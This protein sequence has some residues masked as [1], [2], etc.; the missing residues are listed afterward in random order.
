MFSKKNWYSGKPRGEL[1]ELSTPNSFSASATAMS[2]VAPFSNSNR[3]STGYVQR[4]KFNREND[5][6]RENHCEIEEGTMGSMKRFG[7]PSFTEDIS[8]HTGETCMSPLT[9]ERSFKDRLERLPSTCSNP[10]PFD[11]YDDARRNNGVTD[12]SSCF[13]SG[14]MFN[15][16]NA[17]VTDNDDDGSKTIQSEVSSI[18]ELSVDGLNTFLKS[19]HQVTEVNL[20]LSLQSNSNYDGESLDSKSSSKCL[21]SPQKSSVYGS[22]EESVKTEASFCGMMISNKDS[23]E[24]EAYY[25][26]TERKLILDVQD[27]ESTDDKDIIEWMDSEEENISGANTTGGNNAK[28][29]LKDLNEE[30]EPTD[31]TDDVTST[32]EGRA[33]LTKKI[34]AEVDDLIEKD[35]YLISHE[36]DQVKESSTEE[37]KHARIPSGTIEDLLNCQQDEPAHHRSLFMEA[38][39]EASGRVVQSV[40]TLSENDKYLTNNNDSQSTN[41]FLRE[42]RKSLEEGS[43]CHDVT[44]HHNSE[45]DDNSPVMSLPENDSEDSSSNLMKVL[46]HATQKEVG[47][48]NFTDMKHDT[49]GS[50]TVYSEEVS[51]DSYKDS[52]SDESFICPETEEELDLFLN[53]VSPFLTV[54][55]RAAGQDHVQFT[56]LTITRQHSEDLLSLKYL[57]SDEISTA[58]VKENEETSTSESYRPIDGNSCGYVPEEKDE[59]LLVHETEPM[60]GAELKDVLTSSIHSSN[61]YEHDEPLHSIKLNSEI[62][63]AALHQDD[64]KLPAQ[65][66]PSGPEPIALWTDV[67]YSSCLE[68]QK[69]RE[70]AY[71]SHE[72]A[73]KNQLDSEINTAVS[74]NVADPI[75]RHSQ[76]DLGQCCD[77]HTSIQRKENI[78]FCCNPRDAYALEESRVQNTAHDPELKEAWFDSSYSSQEE[79]LSTCK[80]ND[81]SN[82]N[83]TKKHLQLIDNITLLKEEVE[84]PG[85]EKTLGNQALDEPSQCCDLLTEASFG[86]ERPL[87]RHIL[88]QSQLNTS[89][90]GRNTTSVV[91]DPEEEKINSDQTMAIGS[92]PPSGISA[93][94]LEDEPLTNEECDFASEKPSDIVIEISMCN[95]GEELRKG[96][97]DLAAFGSPS[98]PDDAER[99]SVTILK[100]VHHADSV[101]YE[102]LIQ[103]E[104]QNTESIELS[105][106]YENLHLYKPINEDEK[107]KYDMSIESDC[108]KDVAAPI[109]NLSN[110]D[111]F[112]GVTEAEWSCKPLNDKRDICIELDPSKHV[113]APIHN[114]SDRD[115]VKSVTETASYDH[116]E[117]SRKEAAIDLTEATSDI[118]F[119]LLSKA[120]LIVESKERPCLS[121]INNL[122]DILEETGLQLH[123]TTVFQIMLVLSLSQPSAWPISLSSRFFSLINNVAN[124]NFKSLID[125]RDVIEEVALLQF[126]FVLNQFAKARASLEASLTYGDRFAILFDSHFEM[127]LGLQLLR[128]QSREIEDHFDIPSIPLLQSLYSSI[129]Q[130]IC[131][132]K[133]LDEFIPPEHNINSEERFLINT[134]AFP[135][136]MLHECR[137]EFSCSEGALVT[138]TIETTLLHDSVEILIDIKN[139][140][141]I[142]STTVVTASSVCFSSASASCEAN[143]SRVVDKEKTHD[144]FKNIPTRPASQSNLFLMDWDSFSQEVEGIAGEMKGPNPI[145]PCTA[146]IDPCVDIVERKSGRSIKDLNDQEQS[147]LLI[148]KESSSLD[149]RDT[150]LEMYYTEL[151]LV[152]ETNR[153]N[154]SLPPTKEIDGNENRSD[155]VESAAEQSVPGAFQIQPTKLNQEVSQSCIVDIYDSMAAVAINEHFNRV[156]CDFSEDSSASEK[157]V[158]SLSN[159]PANKGEGIQESIPVTLQVGIIADSAN[160]NTVSPVKCDSLGD[161]AKGFEEINAEIHDKME[162]NGISVDNKEHSNSLLIEVG[163]IEKLIP[164]REKADF[165]EDLSFLGQMDSLISNCVE[166]EVEEIQ[167]FIS[168]A[169]DIG[170]KEFSPNLDL[171]NEH[172]NSISDIDDFM[173]A[174]N[175]SVIKNKNLK[176]APCN[177]FDD[178]FASGQ[179]DYSVSNGNDLVLEENESSLP[180]TKNIGIHADFAIHSS[181]SG[182]TESS[183]SHPIEIGVGDSQYSTSREHLD[184]PREID[185]VVLNECEPSLCLNNKMSTPK[186]LCVKQD[187]IFS[188]LN[189]LK[190]LEFPLSPNFP[191][192]CGLFMPQKSESID[193]RD[194]IEMYE[195][196]FGP[197]EE[198]DESKQAED[199]FRRKSDFGQLAM[200]EAKGDK[201]RI[202]Q[203]KLA[204][205][206]PNIIGYSSEADIIQIPVETKSQKTAQSCMAEINGTRNFNDESITTNNLFYPAQGNLAEV[207]SS[208]SRMT[209]CSG[210]QVGELENSTFATTT[211]SPVSPMKNDNVEFVDESEES[212]E[213]EKGFVASPEHYSSGIDVVENAEETKQN[214][215]ALT[216][217]SHTS[218]VVSEDSKCDESL[219]LPA[220]NSQIYLIGEDNFP[221]E[222]DNHLLVNSQQGSLNH[223]RMTTSMVKNIIHNSKVCLDDD[224]EAKKIKKCCIETSVRRSANSGPP[225]GSEELA[226]VESAGA[227][228]LDS[229]TEKVKQKEFVSEVSSLP[230]SVKSTLGEGEDSCPCPE[231]IKEVDAGLNLAELLEVNTGVAYSSSS[232]VENEVKANVVNQSFSLA[233]SISGFDHLKTLECALSTCFSEETCLIDLKQSLSTVS[234]DMIQQFETKFGPMEEVD[235]TEQAEDYLR[236]CLESNR[237]ASVP[238][239]HHSCCA[240]SAE[241]TMSK[242]SGHDQEMTETMVVFIDN[243]VDC[244]K[245]EQM[246]LACDE[247]RNPQATFRAFERPDGSSSSGSVIH[248]SLSNLAEKDEL[249]IADKIHNTS[250]PQTFYEL[251]QQKAL[252]EA[253]STC[254]SQDRSK[255]EFAES[256]DIDGF[257]GLKSNKECANKKAVLSICTQRV[258]AENASFQ[259]T[260]IPNVNTSAM[261]RIDEDTFTS[262]GSSDMISKYEAKFGPMAEVDE[263]DQAI[264]F[265]NRFL[266]LKAGGHFPN[267]HRD[268]VIL[269]E[270]VISVDE[271]SQS[272]VEVDLVLGYVKKEFFVTFDD[273]DPVNDAIIEV[274]TSKSIDIQKAVSD[275]RDDMN[276]EVRIEVND[277]RDYEHLVELQNN[278]SETRQEVDETPQLNHTTNPEMLLANKA[279][280]LGQVSMKAKVGM[281][282]PVFVNSRTEMAPVINRY[283]S[284]T[285]D[286]SVVSSLSLFDFEC[287]ARSQ[288]PEPPCEID[289]QETAKA[290]IIHVKKDLVQSAL[291][292]F[293][294][295][296]E[297]EEKLLKLE[298]QQAQVALQK[299]GVVMLGWKSPWSHHP[300]SHLLAFSDGHINGTAAAAFLS[301]RRAIIFPRQQKS[302]NYIARSC[303][304]GIDLISFNESMDSTCHATKLDNLPWEHRNVRQRFLSEKS[305]ETCNWFG[306]LLMIRGND[307]NHLPV[308]HPSSAELDWEIIP[309]PGSW[310]ENWFTPWQA[311]RANPNNLLIDQK[312]SND[313]EDSED[314]VGERP[315]IGVL[316]TVRQNINESLT[317]VSYMHSSNL[318]RSRWRRKFYPYGT[319]PF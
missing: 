42:S 186:N 300:G 127:P 210:I 130:N 317:R 147:S 107:L 1:S 197:M 155:Q 225:E 269:P 66:T 183:M 46:I 124:Q 299:H 43:Q 163:N 50:T 135:C 243:A 205:T 82:E 165:A 133:A 70:N 110:R 171:S 161:F 261:V 90:Q 230:S 106:K 176:P 76:D 6:D 95:Q 111:S 29:M 315:Q 126:Y 102:Q 103:F 11:R 249:Q 85:M 303:K 203:I 100:V 129:K 178:S 139:D 25:I 318:R 319:F 2:D 132:H 301:R 208:P 26:S 316:V 262:E 189:Q 293:S 13:Q 221:G 61:L 89:L 314:L 180:I 279:V 258:M 168:V 240:G 235:V 275:E 267:A 191:E 113:A 119:K 62:T 93:T 9:A 157:T 51:L 145:I 308:S 289:L 141:L 72:S 281:T 280:P 128:A 83:V 212:G 22:D 154:L 268:S 36:D 310:E 306:S 8:I 313:S 285:D 238:S 122:F 192:A 146:N 174:N 99:H 226:I 142:Q 257:K 138:E 215:C 81:S 78:E 214:S 54:T 172:E 202:Q 144:T 167:D 209:G 63:S 160:C 298:A 28:V 31:H 20:A 309:Y 201:D 228:H 252:E 224:G 49:D 253:L 44:L 96:I 86:E 295:F 33:T 283:E 40:T 148:L 284:H 175:E 47:P 101:R 290:D 52:D 259:S 311:F 211:I 69:S 231:K 150:M 255:A 222:L 179:T 305:I 88:D 184:T 105:C 140:H 68:E 159:F 18:N 121:D 207:S 12:F 57:D 117:Y 114:L 131:E 286:L 242:N 80:K 41:S 263:S 35:S 73:I 45:K 288:H 125:E 312:I 92:A 181:A 30:N 236:R 265:L 223:D 143:Q 291:S 7:K 123:A 251:N 302:K 266:A 234:Q 156:Q 162:R 246:L 260:T 198:V 64:T 91:S 166:I 17:D 21:S 248:E 182:Q 229:E 108:S 254:S 60:T 77:M 118:E 137:S 204:V 218:S 79:N 233:R 75:V 250:L 27:V 239:I 94:G 87:P 134:A 38:L 19:L 5:E 190:T 241:E 292:L 48:I 273:K 219:R 244:H 193:S 10:A 104:S 297:M 216:I 3:P 237:A 55:P 152:D 169:E 264:G 185:E 200:T 16:T 23:F 187:Q 307:R 287:E 213:T 53:H 278:P 37:R 58:S 304:K 247:K 74:N 71:S 272:C 277:T 232:F 271:D 136:Q 120:F 199:F 188:E 56:D 151:G 294:R 59:V 97:P 24:N 109:S 67:S 296:S 158:T 245:K 177:R 164:V 115:S 98:L 227:D 274:K 217:A 256:E 206:E 65:K 170:R 39:N 282:L 196:K 173:E 153:S 270:P 84:E 149:N 4:M 32:F 276:C 14:T 15:E 194:I 112:I 195:A 34:S 220:C 116:N